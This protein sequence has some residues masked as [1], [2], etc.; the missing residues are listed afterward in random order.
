MTAY[1]DAAPARDPLIVGRRFLL[2]PVVPKW[3]CPKRVGVGCASH[4]GVTTG[5]GEEK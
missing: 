4:H 1:I 2:G 3:L 5:R